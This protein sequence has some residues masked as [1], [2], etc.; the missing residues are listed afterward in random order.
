M[1]W[2]QTDCTG[3]DTEFKKALVKAFGN[4]GTAIWVNLRE[5]M[6]VEIEKVFEDWELGKIDLP[7]PRM[8]VG[9][10]YLAAC[11]NVLPELLLKVLR[12][13]SRQEKFRGYVSG[14]GLTRNKEWVEVVM[15]NFLADSDR[16]ASS[17][18]NRVCKKRKL[19]K[20]EVRAK[21]GLT[22]RTLDRDWPETVHT[23]YSEQ[24]QSTKAERSEE[25]QQE[26][27]AGGETVETPPPHPAPPSPPPP[28]RV[29]A[30]A[31]AASAEAPNGTPRALPR[32]DLPHP[33]G[34]LLLLSIDFT[35]KQVKDFAQK[36]PLAE[37]A[38]VV[39][40][41]RGDPDVRIKG[42]YARQLLVE[43]WGKRRA[44]GTDDARDLLRKIEEFE[45][46]YAVQKRQ[47]EDPFDFA[48]Q[49]YQARGLRVGFEALKRA[50]P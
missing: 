17:F 10:K 7:V 20:E 13:I 12:F 45:K 35:R 38:G 27:P 49:H 43:G 18:I 14:V 32:I 11:C 50:A 24:Q 4:D 5:V 22:S 30:P 48:V 21:L 23:V 28:P 3:R 25:Q 36:Y 19:D 44:I 16:Y 31:A 33:V 9:C 39:G 40:E 29:A 46:I 1:K 37:V 2:I 6:A 8:T 26:A 41:A 42:A 15:P 47:D 34:V